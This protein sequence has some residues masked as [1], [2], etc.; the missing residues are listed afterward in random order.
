M[1]IKFTIQFRLRSMDAEQQ[2]VA[3]SREFPESQEMKKV[4]LWH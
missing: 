1:R 3:I 4:E 2:K